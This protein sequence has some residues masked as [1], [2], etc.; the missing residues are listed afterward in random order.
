MIA[1]SGVA[2]GGEAG[3]IDDGYRA[4]PVEITVG[5]VRPPRI[6]A[7]QGNLAQGYAAAGDRVIVDSPGTRGLGR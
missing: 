4:D 3:G 1:S 5:A 6:A 7:A 2:F